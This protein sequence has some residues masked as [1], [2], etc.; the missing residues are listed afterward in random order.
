MRKYFGLLFAASMMLPVGVIT[1]APAAAASA[2]TCGKAAGTANFKPGLPPI[3]DSS[4]VKS[5]L[6]SKG[7]VSG[8]KGVKG[9]KSG[10]TTFKQ[11]STSTGTNCTMLASP[12]KSDK[13]TK[14]ILTVKWNNGKSSVA[15]STAIKQSSA[16]VANISGK[17]TTGLFKG[18]T[19][20]ATVEFSVPADGSCAT[21]PLTKVTYKNKGKTVIK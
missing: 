3:G 4:T 20:K 2:P 16:T 14:G 10:K 17:I 6:T 7:T 18:K 13:P 19:F 5:K 15:K 11:T 21:K 1:A 8:C 12:K 9:I